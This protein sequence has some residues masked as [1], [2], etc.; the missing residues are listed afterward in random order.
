MLCGIGV[1]ATL[2]L[3]GFVLDWSNGYRVKYG[4]QLLQ[5]RVAKQIST[6]RIQRARIYL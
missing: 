1:L 4:E 6:T 2:W 3:A 5:R